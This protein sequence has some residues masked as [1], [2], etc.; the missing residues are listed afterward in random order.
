MVEDFPNIHETLGS[1]PSVK[2][3]QEIVKVC[4]D[5]CR[6]VGEEETL[7]VCTCVDMRVQKKNIGVKTV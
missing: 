4:T 7:G 5:T 1:V 3:Q 6:G 2:K